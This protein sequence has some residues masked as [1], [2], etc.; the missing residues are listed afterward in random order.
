ME[1]IF[2]NLPLDIKKSILLYDEHFI[3]RK[4]EIISI[5]PKTDYR[6]NLLKFITFNLVYVENDNNRQSYKYYF[7]NL[8]NYEERQINN[9]DLIHVTLNEYNDFIKYSIWIG[10][11]YP[12]SI[13]CNKKQNYYIENPCKYIWNYIEYNYIRR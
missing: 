3:M 11:Q 4:G 8:Y 5:I 9:S 10:R 13:N 2:C 7:Y 1:F 6:Y 12:R